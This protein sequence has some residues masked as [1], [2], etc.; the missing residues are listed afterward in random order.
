M[1]EIR[2]VQTSIFDSYAQHE[3]GQ[4]LYSLSELL[5]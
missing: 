1:R 3:H 5:D 2:D 4:M